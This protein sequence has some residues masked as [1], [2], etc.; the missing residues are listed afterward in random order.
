MRNTLVKLDKGKLP[1]LPV[2]IAS[3]R[4]TWKD[5]DAW[6]RQLGARP[7]GRRERERLR[8]AGLAGMPQ[9]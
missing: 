9:E 4:Y 7:I 6:M 5:I 1:A 2:R 8:K 3:G